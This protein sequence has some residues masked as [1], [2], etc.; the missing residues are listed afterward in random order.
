MAKKPAKK[1][2]GSKYAGAAKSRAIG[3]A[4]KNKG[5]S[6]GKKPLKSGYKRLG[7]LVA[8]AMAVSLLEVALIFARIL[9]PIASYSW[10]NVLFML[11]RIGIVVYTGVAFAKPDLR[12]SFINGATVS[13][14]ASFAMCVGAIVGFLHVHK[15]VLGIVIWDSGFLQI[16]IVIIMAANTLIGTLIAGIAGWVARK[17]GIVK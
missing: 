11:A 14:A 3:H 13:F 6:W 12:V 2:A 5:K 17:A 1:P 9:P 7:M 10:G 15:P 4:P 8:L 16:L